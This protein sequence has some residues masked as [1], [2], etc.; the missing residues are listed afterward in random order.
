MKLVVIALLALAAAGCG[1]D[2]SSS[3]WLTI[4]NDT[5]NE[6]LADVI[7]VPEGALITS[8]Q[9][10]YNADGIQAAYAINFRL[11][12]DLA[13][14]DWLEEI[15]GMTHLEKGSYLYR[16]SPTVYE[17]ENR[18]FNQYTRL[19]YKEDADIYQ[20]DFSPYAREMGLL[21]AL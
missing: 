2:N 19:S 9:A 17:L 4:D 13:P 15:R 18:T 6:V 16:Q 3:G 11:P 5:G 20:L 10:Y 7:Y 1:S 14:I 12:D 21:D 8:T